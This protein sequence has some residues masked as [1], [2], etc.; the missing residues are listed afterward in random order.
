MADLLDGARLEE[1]QVEALGLHPLQK[2][3]EDALEGLGEGAR[4]EHCLLRPAHL[5]LDGYRIDRTLNKRK[6]KRA[7]FRK[8]FETIANL[9][10]ATTCRV[11]HA[12]MKFFGAASSAKEDAFVP[13]S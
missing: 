5:L 8:G 6:K 10:N 3:T 7:P 12:L 4:P 2:A 1:R 9:W 13:R 11:V